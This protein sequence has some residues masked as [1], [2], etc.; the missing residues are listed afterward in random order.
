MVKTEFELGGAHA[1]NAAWNREYNCPPNLLNGVFPTGLYQCTVFCVCLG[2]MQ[3]S[4]VDQK[5]LRDTVK[6]CF[7]WGKIVAKTIMLW[8]AFE[9]RRFRKSVGL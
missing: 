9:R 2:S 8:Q 5:E 7:L 1:R 4:I 6:C 3:R